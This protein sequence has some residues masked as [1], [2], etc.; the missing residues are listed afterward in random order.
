MTK[1]KERAAY[2]IVENG[3]IYTYQLS[4]NSMAMF[5][6]LRSAMRE[7]DFLCN[8]G[9]DVSIVRVRIVRAGRR[10]K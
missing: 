8:S 7:K 1:F 3:A 10:G 9:H 5:K 6:T 2:A 4:Y